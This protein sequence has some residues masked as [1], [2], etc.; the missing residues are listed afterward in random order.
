VTEENKFTQKELEFFKTLNTPFKIQ[1]YLDK[2]PYSA[3]SRYRCPRTVI[4]DKVAH[5]F[6][7]ALFAAAALRNIGYKPVIIDMIAIR[8]DDHII[9]IY[10][11]NGLWG[12]VAKSNFVGLRFREPIYRTHRELV[13]S[14]FNAYHN[15]KWEKSLRGYIGPFNLNKYDKFNWMYS[16]ENLEEIEKGLNNAKVI[17][18]FSKE[19]VKFFSPMDP[20]AYKANMLG[21]D[22]KGV[23]K[24]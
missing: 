8:D 2:I 12:A 3:E 16:D 6:D 20:R 24:P 23:Y 17:N 7:G 13:I 22:M 14:Y 1:Q 15:L 18:L 9:A 10:K 4:K 11:K 5:C 19:T 21:T